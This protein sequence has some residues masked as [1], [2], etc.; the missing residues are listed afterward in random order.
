LGP[1]N[2][3][4]I[5]DHDAPRGKL[6]ARTDADKA[7]SLNWIERMRKPTM[8]SRENLSVKLVQFSLS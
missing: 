8:Q 4:L 7:V 3:G 6:V 5:I 2:P 1:D